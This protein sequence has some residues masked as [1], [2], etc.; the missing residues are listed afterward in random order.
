M[1]KKQKREEIVLKPRH[2]GAVTELTTAPVTPGRWGD[3]RTLFGP[4]GAYSG[5]WCMFLRLGAKAFD[6][7]CPRG[8]AANRRLLAEVVAAGAEPGLL[9]YRDGAP[10]G[11]VAVAP[12]AVYGRVLRSPVHKPI[13]DAGPVYSI[14]C[15]FIAK[16]ARGAGIADVLLNAAVE[17]ASARGA[18]IVEAYPTDV[19]DERPTAAEMWR[20][21]LKQF[22]RAGFEV[23]ARRKPARPIVRK[24][25]D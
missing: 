25:L 19:G 10:V 6:A 16:A 3:L 2:A 17:F 22:E 8:G 23:A 4:N 7:N 18:H 11:W 9:A 12:R 24:I 13:D 20:G 21:S 14:T 1:A 15:F 5:C